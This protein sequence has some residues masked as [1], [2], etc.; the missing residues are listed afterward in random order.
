MKCRGGACPEDAVHEVTYVNHEFRQELGEVL[1]C[2][3][4]NEFIVEYP[5]WVT[6]I[7]ISYLAS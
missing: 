6:V 3:H 1:C 7:A 2:R 5:S 4:F